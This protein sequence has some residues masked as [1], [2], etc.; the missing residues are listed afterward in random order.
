M[1]TML[2]DV[3]ENARTIQEMIYHFQAGDLIET[4][5]VKRSGMF[6]GAKDFVFGKKKKT[7]VTERESR[8]LTITLPEALLHLDNPH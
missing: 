2:H 4:K 1:S 6:G 7:F 3:V 8:V 5:K